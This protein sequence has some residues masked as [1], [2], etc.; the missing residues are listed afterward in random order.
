MNGT[1]KPDWSLLKY[2]EA[3]RTGRRLGL[4]AELRP[5]LLKSNPFSMAA[6]DEVMPHKPKSKRRP[7]RGSPRKRQP[8]P[9]DARQCALIADIEASVARRVREM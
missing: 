7:K 8:A 5:R 1:A 4:A 2:A 9:E 6:L 3:V